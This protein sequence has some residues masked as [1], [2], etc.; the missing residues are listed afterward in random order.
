MAG[1]EFLAAIANATEEGLKLAPA[2]AGSDGLGVEGAMVSPAGLLSSLSSAGANMGEWNG[3]NPP[4]HE[5][6]GEKQGVGGQGERGDGGQF[7]VIKLT[8]LCHTQ[9]HIQ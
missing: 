5:E 2:E 3:G 4:L 1:L 6:G 8:P 7:Y 9:G